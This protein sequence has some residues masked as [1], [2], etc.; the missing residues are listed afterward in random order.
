MEWMLLPL[1]RYAQFSGRSQ[2]KEYW[3][4]VLFIVITSIVLS[5]LDSILGL[6]GGMSR[7]TYSNGTTFGTAA[8]LNGGLLNGV[9]S[10]AIIIPSIAV[11][12]RRLHDIGKSGWWMLIG[13][14]PLVGWIIVIVWYCMDGTHGPNRFGPDPK[15]NYSD[16]EETFR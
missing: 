11:A 7:T 6:G 8:N 16:L 9:F 1:K 14:I 13:L 10:L 5:M 2:R 3:M 4:F 15:G 12:A